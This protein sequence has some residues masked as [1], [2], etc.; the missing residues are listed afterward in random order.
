MKIFPSP[1][2][3]PCTFRKRIQRQ[4]PR[5]DRRLSAFAGQQGPGPQFEGSKNRPRVHRVV[6]GRKNH[7]FCRRRRESSTAER[8]RSIPSSSRPRSKSTV[9]STAKRRFPESRQ[10]FADA[11]CQIGPPSCAACLG[12]PVDTFG[13]MNEPLTLR[14]YDEPEFPGPNGT[15]QFPGLPGQPPDRR[16]LGPHRKNHRSAKCIAQSSLRLTLGRCMDGEIRSAG[17][18]EHRTREFVRNYPNWRDRWGRRGF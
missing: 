3:T 4:Q 1:T 16:R 14:Q 17:K 10:I 7:R 2:P 15:S 12:G 18:S 13:R 11:G 6:H 5:T 9:P 8:S